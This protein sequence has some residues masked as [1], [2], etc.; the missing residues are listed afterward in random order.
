MNLKL[1][2][3]IAVK[4]SLKNQV[5]LRLQYKKVYDFD[6]KYSYTVLEI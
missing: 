4:L 6:V 3:G 2:I 1:N 5:K